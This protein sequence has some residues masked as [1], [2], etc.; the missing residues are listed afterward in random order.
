MGMGGFKRTLWTA[1]ML[2]LCASPCAAQSVFGRMPESLGGLPAD[3]PPESKTP[4]Q[5]PAV[6]DMPPPR[7]DKTLSD[8]QQL[9]LLNQLENARDR[10]VK[11]ADEERE[12]GDDAPKPPQVTK[13][14]PSAAKKPPKPAAQA[15]V[16]PNP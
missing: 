10:Q 2:A 15:G 1:G 4:Y 11:R 5:Y 14:K 9:D 3:A 7:N 8:D 13:K 6:H 12:A 16:K